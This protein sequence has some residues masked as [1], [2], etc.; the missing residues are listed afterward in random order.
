MG[1]ELLIRLGTTVTTIGA[2]AWVFIPRGTTHGWKN[3]G[4]VPVQASYTFTPSDGAKV[5]EESRSLGH[6][7]S[8]NPETMAN[9]QALMKR[10]SFELVAREWE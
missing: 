8:D 4:S 7:P 10:Y 2:G 5:F 3:L 9:F 6:Y 1:G